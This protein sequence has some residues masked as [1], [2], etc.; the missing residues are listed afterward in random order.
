MTSRRWAN[1]AIVAVA[2]LLLILVVLDARSPEPGVRSLVTG[3]N[4][5]SRIEIEAHDQARIVLVRREQAHQQTNGENDGENEKP[6]IWW[7]EHP[8]QHPAQ[9]ARIARLLTMESNPI[10]RSFAKPQ[11][12][13]E[14]QLDPPLARFQFDDRRYQLG[15]SDPL[16]GYRYIAHGQQ[17]S[18]LPDDQLEL[19][20]SG[21]SGLV[22]NR[23]I[24][25]GYR[26]Q[27][28]TFGDKSFTQAKG[29]AP[30][31]LDPQSL[32]PQSLGP[33]SSGK[34]ELSADTM[35]KILSAWQDS[36]AF[37]VELTDEPPTPTEPIEI[38]WQDG[39]PARTYFITQRESELLVY[40]AETG[41]LYH[42]PDHSAAALLGE[43]PPSKA[44]Q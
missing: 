19:L 25:P 36:R 14:F 34:V 44:T 11:Q 20:L 26:I 2:G 1:L 41:L 37:W 8:I 27:Q 29:T 28:W 5:I 40:L 32:G 13:K 17:I 15:G 3:S 12:L 43:N 23:L 22:S 39:E 30:Q 35:A 21:P 9:A 38:R 4:P 31:S 10:Q 33:Q 7:M 6:P 18:L 16:Y 24:P 42:L